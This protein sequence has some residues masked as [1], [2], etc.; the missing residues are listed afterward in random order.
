MPGHDELERRDRADATSTAG[1]MSSTATSPTVGRRRALAL[2]VVVVVLFTMG[3]VLPLD[4]YVEALRLWIAGLGPWGPLVFAAIYVVAT[5]LALPGSPLSLVAGALFGGLWGTVVIS[6]ASTLGAAAAFLLARYVARD[7]VAARLG[8]HATFKRLD[9]LTARYGAAMVAVTRLLPLFPFNLL[10]YGFGLT[11]VGFWTYLG[12]SWLC[13][14]PGTVLYVAGTDVLVRA[15]AE[16][17]IP[18]AVLA[19]VAIAAMLLVL[20][21]R[22]LRRRFHLQDIPESQGTA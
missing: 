4:A 22:H 3:R 19:A 7:V 15:L 18:W 12:W 17:R 2:A 13:M 6:F 14:L 20:L 1:A 11:R 21:G 16:G 8:D 5:V 9:A 10:N